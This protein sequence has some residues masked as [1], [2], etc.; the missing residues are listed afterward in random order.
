MNENDR[1]IAE[2]AIAGA[3]EQIKAGTLT[4]NGVRVKVIGKHNVMAIFP[5]G[6]REVVRRYLRGW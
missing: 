5:P 4:A 6:V 3:Q 1:Q 2:Q